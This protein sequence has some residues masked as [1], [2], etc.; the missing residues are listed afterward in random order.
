M[1]TSTQ[2]SEGFSPFIKNVT[3]I[4][5]VL[6]DITGVLYNSAQGGGHAIEGSVE[7]VKRL[8]KA[9]L[10]VRFCTNETQCTTKAIV[11]KLQRL[12]FEL[13]ESEV[14][15]PIPAVCSLM[16][17]RALRPHILAHPASLS[18][19]SE[20]DQT[21]PNCVVVGDAAD[22]FTYHNLNKAFRILISMETPVL[23]SLGQGK[24]YR[25]DDELSLDVGAFVKAL[26]YA[27]D[28]QAEVVGKPSKTFFNTALQD[29]NVS[30][31]NAVMVGDDILNDVG[32]A[33][34]C[35]MY[36]IQV[37]TGK[38]R[39]QDEH[40]PQVTPDA[41]VDNLAAAVDLLLTHR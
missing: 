8:R 27:C 36:G 40:H 35:G 41:V 21:N 31:E 15:P 14:F 9:G 7:A 24:F 3:N 26:E 39:P 5:G 12:G 11:E 37:R 23:F 18:D 30:P 33:Q 20:I 28:V 2:C 1:A 13:T 34:K 38:F 22:M 10:P 17:A 16:K 4:K 32:G 19:F 6:L 29:M 25:E